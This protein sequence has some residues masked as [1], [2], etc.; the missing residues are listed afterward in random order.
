M[1]M[2]EQFY[3]ASK[4]DDICYHRSYFEGLMEYEGWDEMTLYKA[5]RQD[6]DGYFWC[7]HY[8]M[9]GEKSEGGCGMQ[10]NAYAPK[11]G[12]SGCCKYYSL[13]M[14]EPTDETLLLRK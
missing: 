4:D 1:I 13:K 3:F 5:K 14:Y 7:N 11:N 10:C 12:K 8:E 9:V 2:A 6:V